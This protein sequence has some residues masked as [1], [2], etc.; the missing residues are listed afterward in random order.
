VADRGAD[1]CVAAGEVPGAREGNLRTV[2]CAVLDP[3][4]PIVKVLSRLDPSFWVVAWVAWAQWG[5][6]E[7][8]AETNF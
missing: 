5:R 2:F 7:W 1:L 6:I 3:D 4:A 8:L